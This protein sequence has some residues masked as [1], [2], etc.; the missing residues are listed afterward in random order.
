ME[1]TVQRMDRLIGELVH[2]TPNGE[3]R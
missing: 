1:S 3:L 2:F